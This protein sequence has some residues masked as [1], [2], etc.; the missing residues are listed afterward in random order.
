MANGD[1]HRRRRIVVRLGRRVTLAEVTSVGAAFRAPSARLAGKC[2][3]ALVIPA[4]GATWCRLRGA[5][6]GQIWP[7]ALGH[8][9]RRL[10]PLH[11]DQLSTPPPEAVSLFPGTYIECRDG[12]VGRLDGLVVE[13]DTG[14]TVGF[15]VRARAG[16]G[17]IITGPRDPLAH[18]LPVAGQTLL[19]PPAWA[20]APETVARFYGADHHLKIDATAAQVARCLTLRDDATLAQEIWTLLGQNKAIAPYIE[21]FAITVRDGAVTITGPA[22]SH[23]LSAAVEQ[24]VWHIPGVLDVTNALR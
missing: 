3:E 10:I 9:S 1:D 19:V 22:L 11:A 13:S 20:K 21:R 5:V 2:D 14:A 8:V 7:P 23:R 18:M 12:Y 6:G 24:D 17:E 15:L 4:T 16:L